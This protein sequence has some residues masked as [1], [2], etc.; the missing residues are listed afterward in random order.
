MTDRVKIT[1]HDNYVLLN[2]KGAPLSPEE[3]QSTLSKAIDIAIESNLNIIIN[4]VKLVRQQA[5]KVSFYQYAQFLNESSFENKL[6]LVF[7]E[8]LRYY[9][10]DFFE[11]AATNRGV[12]LKLFSKLEE[13]INWI[14]SDEASTK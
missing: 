9:S 14:G 12:R 6:A 11:L 8:E 10:L 1:K 4:R 3:I 7:P 13:A 2:V 5:S